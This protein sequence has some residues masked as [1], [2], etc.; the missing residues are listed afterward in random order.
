MHQKIEGRKNVVD[1]L[2]K[3]PFGLNCIGATEV[4][5]FLNTIHGS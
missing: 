4:R 3:I 1:I 5:V 2:K